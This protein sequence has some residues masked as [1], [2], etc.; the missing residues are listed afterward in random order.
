[1]IPEL[2]NDM[3]LNWHPD[4]EA[5]SKIK[6]N[7]QNCIFIDQ[8][9]KVESIGTPKIKSSVE[10]IKEVSKRVMEIIDTYKEKVILAKMNVPEIKNSYAHIFADS[11]DIEDQIQTLILP[12]EATGECS[13]YNPP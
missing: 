1:M 11:V 3:L 13:N 8:S 7:L 6:E 5:V 10:F 9:I 2:K 4:F 12:K